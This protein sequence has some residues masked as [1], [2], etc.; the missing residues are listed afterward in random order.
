MY[1]CKETFE[2]ACA[3]E[4]EQ[5]NGVI[6]LEKFDDALVESEIVLPVDIAEWVKAKYLDKD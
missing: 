6:A 2:L 4:D 1:T 5:E 3:Q